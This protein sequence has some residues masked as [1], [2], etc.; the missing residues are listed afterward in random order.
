[1]TAFAHIRQVPELLRGEAN[2]INSWIERPTANRVLFCFAVILIGAGA[3][4]AAVGIWRAPLQSIYTAVKFPMLVLLTTLGNA[5]LNGM[6]APLLGLDLAFRQSLVAILM[7]FTIAAAIL[8]AFSPLIFFLVWNTPPLSARA[9]A[10]S[11]YSVVLLVQV[12]A[13]AFAGIAA[14]LRLLQLLHRLSGSSAIAQKIMFTWLAGNL[15][16]GSQLSWNLRPFVGSPGLPVEFLRKEA[17]QGNFF[18]SVFFAARQ[19]VSPP[20][21]T[22]KKI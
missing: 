15:L 22:L 4:G 14:N 19:L 8:G 2:V 5:L 11:A 20:T 7:S 12:A 1:M 18:E 13:I 9:Q 3:F 17:F 6:L 16:L 10:G 21:R